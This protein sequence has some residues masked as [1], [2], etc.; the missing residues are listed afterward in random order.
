[1]LLIG[2]TSNSPLGASRQTVLL[3]NVHFESPGVSAS[4]RCLP[5][6]AAPWWALGVHRG[7]CWQPA[8]RV[9]VL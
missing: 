8:S 1:M 7:A 9:G 2:F 4:P 3:F 5:C 6:Q